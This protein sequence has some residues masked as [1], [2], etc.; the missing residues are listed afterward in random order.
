MEYEKKFLIIGNINAITYKEFFP[1]LKD[2]KV[3]IGYGF[4][5]SVVYK[6]P[7][8]NLLE[9]NKT[10]VV[11]KGF[12]PNEG[13][14]KVPAICWY[15]NLDISKRHENLILYKRYNEE[16]HPKYDNYDAINVDKVADIPCDYDGVIGVPITFMDKYNPAQFKIVELSRY[17]KDCEGMKEE[18]VK[19]YYIQGGTGQITAGH[20]D[21]C[22][23]DKNGKAI[24]PYMRI[25]IQK[26][27][28][29]N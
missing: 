10:F 9:S 8:P 18:F 13:Y 14:V 1:L 21:L 15:T 17:L 29:E 20:P 16:E 19:T 6:T 11:S 25:L 23:Y 3:W 4:N 27:N 26:I 12:D 5:L 7:Y 24:V 2:N 22:Y 28:K